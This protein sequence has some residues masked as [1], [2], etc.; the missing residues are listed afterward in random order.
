MDVHGLISA[1]MR[2]EE[3]VMKLYLA[4]AVLFK[5]KSVFWEKLAAEEKIHAKMLKEIIANT[6][7]GEFKFKKHDIDLKSIEKLEEFILRETKEAKG[8]RIN[9]Q[10]ALSNALAIERDI[11]EKE[12]SRVIDCGKQDINKTFEKLEKDTVK[13]AGLIL[14]E[15]ETN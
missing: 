2:N 5:E 15:M 8:N 6:A 4:Y 10:E 14:N 12:F 13:H 11:V 3:N 9:L 1:I 7:P